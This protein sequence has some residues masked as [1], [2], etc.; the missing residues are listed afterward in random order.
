MVLNRFWK[1]CKTPNYHHHYAPFLFNCKI[2]NHHMLFSLTFYLTWFQC[3]IILWPWPIFY[4]LMILSLFTP[5]IVFSSVSD[6]NL[7]IKTWLTPPHPPPPPPHPTTTNT[8]NTT[9]L[10]NKVSNI[11]TL[12]YLCSLETLSFSDFASACST[13]LVSVLKPSIWLI[14]IFYVNTCFVSLRASW[15]ISCCMLN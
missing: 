2:R 8:T 9:S 15:K 12:M 13:E 14:C 4:D 1:G 10:S 3:C 7:V 6:Y 5:I 11:M